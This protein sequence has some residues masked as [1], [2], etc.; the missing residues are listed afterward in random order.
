MLVLRGRERWIRDGFDGSGNP[1]VI[2]T[3]GKSLVGMP[4]QM[5][6]L[7]LNYDIS[8]VLN[9]N[10]SA[11]HAGDR[12]YSF[13]ND[14]VAEGYTTVNAALK[15][16]LTNFRKGTY[17][18]LNISNLFDERYLHGTGY[19]NNNTAT[20]LYQLG[21]PRTASLTLRTTF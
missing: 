17:L 12:F 16:D 8:P 3:K 4:E 20:V 9:L 1:R 10:L 15:Y 6:T 19:V 21:A 7:G 18:Q 2:P 5:W 13:V 14:E 11:K